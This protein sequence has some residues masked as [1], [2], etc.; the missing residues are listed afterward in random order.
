[1]SSTARVVVVPALDA[2][3]HMSPFVGDLIQS[4]AARGAETLLVDAIREKFIQNQITLTR[5]ELVGT[6]IDESL[7]VRRCFVFGAHVMR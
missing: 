3:F 6:W 2:E 7:F 1:M 5:D 4:A